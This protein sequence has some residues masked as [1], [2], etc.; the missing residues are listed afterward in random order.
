MTDLLL[1]LLDD[2][3][4]GGGTATVVVGN[5]RPWDDG[6]D[7]T[8]TDTEHLHGVGLGGYARGYHDPTPVPGVP[9]DV[10]V[11]VRLSAHWTP[12]PA[13]PDWPPPTTALVA[14]VFG[15]TD[16]PDGASVGT[17]QTWVPFDGSTTTVTLAHAPPMTDADWYGAGYPAAFKA[18]IE[19][20]LFTV[21]TSSGNWDED[22]W[23]D[24]LVRVKVYELAVTAVYTETP[25][26]GTPVETVTRLHPRDD[27]LGMS[28][29]PRLYP[30]PT[31][32]RV[33]GGYR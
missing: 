16:D 33:V 4:V 24:S 7:A 28:S 25:P 15:R 31:R 14:V 19:A 3:A 26:P 12:D 30:R 21:V 27:G 2:V 1:P 10:Q 17:L 5:P 11:T 13:A 32:H 29:A 22:P 20:G 18:A 9:T 8:Y 23:F 6:S